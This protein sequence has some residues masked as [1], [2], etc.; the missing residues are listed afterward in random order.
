MHAAMTRRRTRH[1]RV[2]VHYSL[3]QP[4]GDRHQA[5]FATPNLSR[6]FDPVGDLL[7]VPSNGSAGV[8]AIC[9]SKASAQ[10]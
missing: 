6:R 9:H 8:D 2:A 1:L 3:C 5:T 10:T 4:A 7:S